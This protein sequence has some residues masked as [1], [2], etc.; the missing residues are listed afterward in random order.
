MTGAVEK[1]LAPQLRP[2]IVPD[3]TVVGGIGSV[4]GAFLGVLRG[5][6]AGKMIVQVGDPGE[7]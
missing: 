4:V 7:K 2:G 1:S 5:A 3:D 6:D